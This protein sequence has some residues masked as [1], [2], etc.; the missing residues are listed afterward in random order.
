MKY[1]TDEPFT[2]GTK[3]GYAN[4]ATLEASV[5]GLIYWWTKHR[6]GI[7]FPLF[8]NSLESYVSFLKNNNYFEADE[9]EYLNGCKY[10][11]KQY[12]DE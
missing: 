2:I 9:S 1:Y 12:F 10:F 3:N 8:I 5:A 7:S 4:Y 11:F 6:T